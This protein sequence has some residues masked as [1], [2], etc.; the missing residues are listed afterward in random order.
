MSIHIE[1]ETEDGLTIELKAFGPS[2]CQ[3]VD[4]ALGHE[5]PPPAKVVR[6]AWSN[7]KTYSFFK[8]DTQAVTGWLQKRRAPVTRRQSRPA[9]PVWVQVDSAGSGSGRGSGGSTEPKPAA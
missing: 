5:L 1:T 3:R 8:E 6:H 2:D 7:G 9:P 4:Q